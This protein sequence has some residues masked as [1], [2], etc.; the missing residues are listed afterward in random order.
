MG[1][2]LDLSFREEDEESKSALADAVH[3]V[4]AEVDKQDQQT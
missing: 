1:K 2:P 3:V 4:G